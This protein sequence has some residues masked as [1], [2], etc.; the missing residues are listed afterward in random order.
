MT[1][2]VTMTTVTMIMTAMI[3]DNLNPAGFS[4]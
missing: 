2:I 3:G 1:V 4:R